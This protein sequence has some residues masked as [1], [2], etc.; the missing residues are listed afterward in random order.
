VKPLS[1]EEV[2]SR[3]GVEQA[4]VLRIEGLGALEGGGDGYTEGDVHRVALLHSWEAAGL[5]A[6]SIL[7]AV[8]KGELSLSFLDTPGWS[9][10][11]RPDRTY[12]EL[13]EQHGVPLSLVLGLHDALGFQPPS[14]DD[15]VRQDD[16]VMVE[17]AR[18]LL[19][20]GSPEAAVRR[21]FHLYADNLRRIAAAEADLYQSEVVTPLRR[22]GITETDLMGYGSRLGQD[23]IPLVHRTL[24]RIY[25]RHRQHVWTEYSV[26]L[27]EAALEHAGLYQRVVRPPAICF[28]DL[29]GF[30][31]LTEE[32]GDEVAARLAASLAALVKDISRRH[33]GTSVRWLGDGGMFHFKEPTAGMMAALEMVES[34]PAAGLP[35]THIGIQAGPVVSQDGDV[36]GRT[37]NIASRI[38]GR[39]GPGEVLTSEGTVELVEDAR[40]RFVRIGP[41]TLKGISRPVTLYRVLRSESP[42]PGAGPGSASRPSS[43]AG[44]PRT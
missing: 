36:F 3:A 43:W 34:A 33:D 15:R 17:L 28:V 40:L 18:T 4:Y 12:R 42:S 26:S 20:A 11:E 19:D 23:L 7:T 31:R 44:D 38:A 2:A 14:P 6:G 41:E 29:T 30:T 37:V 21:L 25:E 10:P 39:A 5:A 35:P 16:L 13:S 9:L 24:Q 8:R 27:A 22:E 1:L 32:Q